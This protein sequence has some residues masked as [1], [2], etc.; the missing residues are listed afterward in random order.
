[1]RCGR[2]AELPVFIIVLENKSFSDTFGTSTQD[3]YLQKKLVLMG[4]LLTEY[5]GTGH[6]SLDNYLSLISGQAPTPDTA[7]DCLPGFTGSVGN[8]MFSVIPKAAL[9]FAAGADAASGVAPDSV[10][11]ITFGIDGGNWATNL[12]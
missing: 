1:M 4:A 12:A 2:D 11:L 8:Y 9:I 10:P 5:Y 7:N 3:P 6:V